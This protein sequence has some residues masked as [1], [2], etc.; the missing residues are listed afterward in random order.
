MTLWR[1]CL[2]K[3]VPLAIG[4]GLLPILAACTHSRAN[5]THTHKAE[6][7]TP[8]PLNYQVISYRGTAVS[9]LTIPPGATYAVRPVVADTVDTVAAM[10]QRNG[11]I[12]AINAGFF[13]PNNQKTTSYVT[14]Q[15]E[16]VADPRQNERLVN[17]PSLTAYLPQI[18]NRSE[19]R[20][21]RCGEANQYA[22]TLHQAPVPDHCQLI[23][24]IGGGPQLLPA[25]TAEQEAFTQAIK[26][27]IVRDALGLQ[28]RNARTAVGV[29]PTGQMIWVMVPHRV[30]QPTSGLSLPDLAALL[31]QQGAY[32]AIN[33]DGGSSSV[34]YYRGQTIA[35]KLD[36]AGRS[37][38]RPVKSIL[39]VRQGYPP[40]AGQN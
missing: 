20:R 16:L 23:D 24:A 33:L 40:K 8:A 15:R 11:A 10:A 34:L 9:V 29:T 12:A 3:T 17:N 4:L 1:A 6:V 19:L 31:Q 13:D 27:E 36:A 2:S 25:L 14:I 30:D 21:Y 7:V 5:T 26:G 35:G 22:I 28:Q 38:N 18:L 39:L 37:L 32:Q